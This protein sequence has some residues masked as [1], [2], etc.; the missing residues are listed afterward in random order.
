M[1]TVET[2]SG[3]SQQSLRWSCCGLF[4]SLMLLLS[5][6]PITSPVGLS[7]CLLAAWLVVGQILGRGRADY[8][9]R[10]IHIKVQIQEIFGKHEDSYLAFSE[11]AWKG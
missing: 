11:P 8:I 6:T 1:S 5:L 3:F 9:L 2:V 10:W 7:A 4:I